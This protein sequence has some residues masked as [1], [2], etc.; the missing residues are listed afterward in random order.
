LHEEEHGTDFPFLGWQ[1]RLAWE[2]V[3]A[4]PMVM[5]CPSE[6]LAVFVSSFKE[7]SSLP[8]LPLRVIQSLLGI[9]AWLR[10]AFPLAGAFISPLAD[11]RRQCRSFSAGRR[12]GGPSLARARVS[13]VA[14][15]A[16]LW[17]H[18]LLS[19]WD[20][21][22]PVRAPFGP[23]HEAERHGWV[24][25]STS[26]GVGG[27]FFNP[28]ASPPVLEGFVRPWTESERKMAFVSVRS[29]SGVMEMLGLFVWTLWF[30][31]DCKGCR[32][33]L[34]TDSDAVKLAF[35]KG[36]SSSSAM[37]DHLHDLRLRFA[38]LFVDVRLSAVSG[39]RFN[40]VADLLSRNDEV[41]A[42]CV[43]REMFGVNITMRR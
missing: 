29:S 40:K 7:A 32:L 9:L 25:A 28:S 2:G 35:A 14:R 39:E 19:S 26:F 10:P 30:A 31:T 11:L 41:G 43:A 1:W 42:Q 13:P 4:W 17:C 38:R 20:C 24:D 8:S 33:A 22:A 34:R 6:K 37:M 18:E 27:V 23:F 21:V 3:P 5:I 36:F 12:H 16:L 15:E